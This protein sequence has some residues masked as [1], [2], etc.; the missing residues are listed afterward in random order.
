MTFCDSCIK[1]EVLDLQEFLDGF[2]VAK[3]LNYLIP[4]C[5]LQAII[6]AKITRLCKFPQCNEKVIKRLSN[7]LCSL[8]QI[9]PLHRFIDFSFHVLSQCCYYL[10]LVLFLGIRQPKVPHDVK[11]FTREAQVKG[12]YLCLCWFEKLLGTVCLP[13]IIINFH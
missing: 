1:R 9:S 12:L 10:C 6:V 8:S 4:Q 7:Q 13:I 5:F 3:S 11:G 2:S